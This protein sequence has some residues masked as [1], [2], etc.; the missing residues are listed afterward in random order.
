MT[1]NLHQQ[2]D[3]NSCFYTINAVVSLS[4]IPHV[5]CLGRHHD[6]T[7]THNNSSTFPQ[8]HHSVTSLSNTLA[9]NQQLQQ[10]QT[11]AV[12]NST[13]LRRLAA[14][15]TISHEPIESKNIPTASSTTS[16]GSPTLRQR[17][18]G[19]IRLDELLLHRH[20]LHDVHSRL[21][22]F[23]HHWL[24]STSHCQARDSKAEA[25]GEVGV[26]SISST[27]SNYNHLEVVTFTIES[28]SFKSSCNCFSS[29]LRVLDRAST[30]FHSWNDS[31][32]S[33]S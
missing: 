24:T 26:K 13:S 2:T 19:C 25:S 29:N 8:R 15:E 28:K 32:D 30:F 5:T 7:G 9:N 17:L 18:H 21:D 16:D 1:Y 31:L 27:L 12:F 22:D 3:Q 10:L 23:I 33:C 14:A 20:C 11:L 4:S 6:V